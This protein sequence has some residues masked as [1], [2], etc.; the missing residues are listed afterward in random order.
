MG[1]RL[2][3][4]PRN[5]AAHLFKFWLTCDF[6]PSKTNARLSL[7]CSLPHGKPPDFISKPFLVWLCEKPR[8]LQTHKHVHTLHQFKFIFLFILH[9]IFILRTVIQYG[10]Q[11]SW[12]CGIA[13]SL[14]T[15]FTSFIH[16][17]YQQSFSI[18]LTRS[19][20]PSIISI[21]DYEEYLC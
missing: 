7:I 12:H 11:L 15:L 9:S 4:N 16:F 8:V 19:T 14:L 17:I 10:K 6:S 5:S 2:T 18:T 1:T 21:Y 3:A 13:T 20:C